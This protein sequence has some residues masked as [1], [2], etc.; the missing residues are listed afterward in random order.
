ML[1][2]HEV[3][4]SNPGWPTTRRMPILE[5][6]ALSSRRG[7]AARRR[8]LRGR[9]D[10]GPR[11]P[12]S[13]FRAAANSRAVVTAAR[14]YRRSAAVS[15]LAVAAS[16]ASPDAASQAPRNAARAPR[17]AG[18]TPSARRADAG[19]VQPHRHLAEPRAAP[20][21][22]T[23]YCLRGSVGAYPVA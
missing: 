4:G 19:D 6:N 1:D 7:E 12:D 14:D 11:S 18:A 20:P 5:M 2:K 10:R 17:R 9:D 21:R 13:G 3:P 23:L 15:E 16:G 8:T 22:V